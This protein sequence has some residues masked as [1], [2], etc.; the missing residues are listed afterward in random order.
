VPDIDDT[1]ESTGERESTRSSCLNDLV[2]NLEL[3]FILD[4]EDGVWMI[5]EAATKSIDCQSRIAFLRSLGNP[6]VSVTEG[7]LSR[8]SKTRPVFINDSVLVIVASANESTD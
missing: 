6:A 1:I 3:G 8:R 7:A 5:R 2:V 4:Y